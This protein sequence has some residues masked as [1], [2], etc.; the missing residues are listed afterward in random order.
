MIDEL[1]EKPLMS[2]LAGT[3]YTYVCLAIVK[4]S[5]LVKAIVTIIKPVVLLP[6]CFV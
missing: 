3:N 5:N 2:P 4:F 1:A 6:L